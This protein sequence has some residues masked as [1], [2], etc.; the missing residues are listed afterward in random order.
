MAKKSNQTSELN[1]FKIFG[2]FKLQFIKGTSTLDSDAS[3]T[4]VI[5][6]IDKRYPKDNLDRKGGCYIFAIRTGGKG[7]KGGTYSPWYVGQ[8]KNLSLLEESLST[9]NFDKFYSRIA[10]TKHGTPMLFWIAKAAPGM[11]NSLDKNEIDAMEQELID[12]AAHRNHDLMNTQHIPRLTFRI[13]GLPLSAQ[14]HARAKKGPA[15]KVAK[16]LGVSS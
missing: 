10:A 6:E 16:M 2:P 3:K 4:A 13:E 5:A 1:E 15:A 11:I 12:W 7:A 8:A 9:R 14:S